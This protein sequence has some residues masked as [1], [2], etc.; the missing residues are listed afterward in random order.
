MSFICQRWPY[1]FLSYN[2]KKYGDIINLIILFVRN[3]KLRTK[4]RINKI[5]EKFN[6]QFLI[7]LYVV[8]VHT[9]TH[10]FHNNKNPLTNLKD[11]ILLVTLVR[12]LF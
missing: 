10:G 8:M 4:L 7:N 9:C 6:I 12:R 2:E 5:N 1:V 11:I 3:G